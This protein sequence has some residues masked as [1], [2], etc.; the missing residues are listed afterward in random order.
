MHKKIYL[1]LILFAFSVFSS[2]SC[3]SGPKPEKVPPQPPPQQAP[4][5]TQK[6][7]AEN[8]QTEKPVPQKTIIPAEEKKVADEQVAQQEKIAISEK[9][10][11]AALL[12]EALFT[13][14]EAKLAWERG[15]QDAALQEL[16]KAYGIILKAILP[17]DSPL[18]QDKNNL[19]L[20]I[21]QRIQE[22]YASR[23]NPIN[24]NHKSIPLVENQYVLQELE[25]FKTRERKEFEAAYMRSGLYREFI[26]DELKKAGLPE[27]LRWL[28]VIESWYMVRALSVSRALGLWQF[29]ATT[30]YRYGLV[31]DK[32]VDERMD[33]Y[34]STQ[35]AVKYL[36]ELH[37]FFGEWTTALASYNCGEIRVQNVINSQRINY[38]DNF[39]DLFQRLPY[40][41]ARFVPRFIAA[42]LII[43]NPEK[44]GFN[45]PT[46]YAPLRFET[47]VINHP[48]K[49]STLSAALGLEGS[50]LEYLNPELRYAST[51]D[52]EYQLRIPVGYAEKA[53][54]AI[55]NLPK[56]MPPE[57]AV[58]T[59][60][61]GETLSL[62]ARKYG[63]SVQ[64]LAQ[65]NGLRYPYVLKVGIRLRIP[66]RG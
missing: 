18:A 64:A 55:N 15:D 60:R 48:T 25:L 20:L 26:V 12:D 38:M 65:L 62:I 23:R 4:V 46:P 31:R 37:S 36:T 21:A 6:P 42:A 40:Q 11:A 59:V 7:A 61:A 49:L 5:E 47:V 29:I 58:H 63:T 9:D 17:P 52:R 32:F 43:N 54:Q 57:Y 66:G 27:E 35:A 3:S 34:K 14:Q 13:Y 2:W 16:D 24:D 44:Y 10:D 33:P 19:R 45:L 41:T 56:F 8:V 51:P 39:W 28:P 50:E 1:W 30:G 53:L 22:I